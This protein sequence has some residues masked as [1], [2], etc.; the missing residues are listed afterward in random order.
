MNE[1]KEAVDFNI[2]QSPVVNDASDNKGFP[3][4]SKKRT[5]TDRAISSTDQNNS[6]QLKHGNE[7]RNA[8]LPKQ[9]RRR[10]NGKTERNSSANARDATP[11]LEDIVGQ[12]ALPYVLSPQML[13]KSLSS[14]VATFFSPGVA[15]PIVTAEVLQGQQKL[16]QMQPQR[17]PIDRGISNPVTIISPEKPLPKTL[18][19]LADRLCHKELDGF[20][21]NIIKCIRDNH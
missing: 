15:V 11:P 3:K 7:A 12:A 21:A 16:L 13:H 8:D 17:M 9:S 1:P 18:R 10:K 19:E 4:Q 6:Q 2:N 20:A 5:N 14:P